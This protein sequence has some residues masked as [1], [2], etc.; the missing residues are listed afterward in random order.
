MEIVVRD[1]CE[2]DRSGKERRIVVRVSEKMLCKK[3]E[4]KK[5]R[6]VS[7]VQARDGVGRGEQGTRQ[8]EGL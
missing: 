6:L 4:K 5:T 7:Y 8:E 3:K 1:V 2:K